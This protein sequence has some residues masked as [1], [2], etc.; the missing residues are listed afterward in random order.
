MKIKTLNRIDK[1]VKIIKSIID[2]G[3]IV[4]SFVGFLLALIFSDIL[5]TLID[6]LFMKII[7]NKIKSDKS[8]VLGIEID[9]IKL[10]QL[11]LHIIIKLVIL[12]IIIKIF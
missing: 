10:I 7:K 8:Y 11:G 3:N 2:T 1:N 12:F 5:D 4:N 9:N 6:N